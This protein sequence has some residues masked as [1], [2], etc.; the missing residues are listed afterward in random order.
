M[1]KKKTRSPIAALERQASK[2]TA[3]CERHYQRLRAA[4]LALEKSRKDLAAVNQRIDA[5]LDD[6][7]NEN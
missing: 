6:T 3:E 7:L 1:A 5:A 4:F 2:L